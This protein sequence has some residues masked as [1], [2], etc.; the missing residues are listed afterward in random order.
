MRNAISWQ[1]PSCAL[2][3]ETDTMVNDSGASLSYYHGPASCLAAAHRRS[4]AFGFSAPWLRHHY[5][6]FLTTVESITPGDIKPGALL[7]VMEGPA[8]LI[9]ALRHHRDTRIRELCHRLGLLLTDAASEG[10]GSKKVCALSRNASFA[11][12]AG[13]HGNCRVDRRWNGI[14]S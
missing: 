3:L 12:D 8:G 11:H 9:I 1:H 7:D 14:R 13:R 6:R 2:Q 5:D 4:Q 10:W